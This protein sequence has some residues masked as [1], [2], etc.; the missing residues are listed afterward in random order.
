MN[1]GQQVC[2]TVDRTQAAVVA[3]VR[4]STSDD[5]IADNF[6]FQIVPNGFE[7]FGANRI[8][9]LWIRNDFAACFFFDVADLI[10]TILLAGRLHRATEVVVVRIVQASEQSVVFWRNVFYFGRID[11]LIQLFLQV[12]DVVDD[13]MS[14]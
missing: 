10:G 13:F 7:S 6:F 8:I 14:E 5:Q 11:L 1:A 4:T 12:D 2:F 9:G 3:T